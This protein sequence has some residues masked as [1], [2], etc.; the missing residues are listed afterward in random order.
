[1]RWKQEDA[2]RHLCSQDGDRRKRQARRRESRAA[3]EETGRI[4][5]AEVVQR[6]AAALTGNLLPLHSPPPIS[7]QTSWA[8]A[9]RWG[10]GCRSARKSSTVGS[11]HIMDLHA[12]GG[13]GAGPNHNCNV[14]FTCTRE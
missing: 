5:E 1:M 10:E 3:G 7:T 11:A 8:S 12:Q 6:S 13:C 4:G 9:D 2:G 14:V